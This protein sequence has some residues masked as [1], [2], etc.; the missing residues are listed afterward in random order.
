MAFIGFAVPPSTALVLSDIPVPGDLEAPGTMH[1][2]MLNLG[3]DVPIEMLSKAMTVAYGVLTT[4]RPF[5][6]KTSRVTCFP[7]NSHGVPI[8]C[9]VESPELHELHEKLG[10]ALDEAGVFYSKKF[11]VFK[12]HV[13]LAYASKAIPDR[14]IPTIE[15]GAHELVLW[16][17][18]SG[19]K[20][21]VVHFPLSL[22]DRVAARVRIAN[23]LRT[24]PRLFG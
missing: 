17:G 4:F 2:T 14:S 19:A 7:G 10:K 9:P 3:D 18:D 8:I 24:R 13:T 5:T 22:T 20:R 11:P 21:L 6:M 23:Y 12:P 16:G 15:W 1:V